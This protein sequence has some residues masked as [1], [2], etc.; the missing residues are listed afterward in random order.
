M[1]RLLSSLLL[2]FYSSQLYGQIKPTE[3][4]LEKHYQMSHAQSYSIIKNIPLKN[5]GPSIMGGRVV[6]LAVNPDNPFEFYVAYAT[7]GVWHTDNNGSSFRSVFDS[8]PTQHVGA[9][10]VQWKKNIIWVGTG[11]SNS[12]R[13]SYAGIGILK[14]K[15]GGKTWVSHGL[16]DTHHISKIILHPSDENTVWVASMGHLYTQNSERGVFKTTDSGKSW[17]KTLFISDKTGVI[18]LSIAPNNPNILYAA[19]W[20]R[21]RKSWQFDRDGKES[22]IYK[23]ID[24]GNNWSLITTGENG[25]PNN[26]GIGRIGLAVYN[27]RVIYA[28]LDNQNEKP[29]QKLDKRKIL[30]KRDFQEMT[31]K[32]FLRLNDSKL[33]QYIKEKKI[34]TTAK[35]AKEKVRKGEIAPDALAY[36]LD[37]GNTLLFNTSVIGAE[38]Y[39]S[40]NGGKYWIK[41]HA[42]YL[43]KVYNSY[44]YYFGVIR[45]SSTDENQIFVGGV[46]LI[47]S[48][49]GG[50]SF[51]TLDQPNMHVDHHALWINP[52]NQKHLINGNDGGVD[53]SFDGG[54]NW[55][56][57]NDPPVGQL[58]AV[59][60]DYEMPYNIYGGFQDNGV[61]YGK[62]T[63]NRNLEWQ[64]TGEYPYRILTDGDGMQTQIDNTNR[65]TVIIGC[66]FGDYFKINKRTKGR[67]NVKPK[68]KLGQKP[69][70][71]N[72][73]TPILLSK[74][75]KNS[76]YIGSQY[77]H[78]SADNGNTFEGITK[79]LTLGGKGKK[80]S[81]IYGTLTTIS[82]SPFSFGKL[83]VGSDDGLIHRTEDNGKTWKNISTGLPENMWVSRV[84][85]SFHSNTQV[86]A[87]LNG[88][89]WDNFAP[90]VYLSED[91]GDHWKDISNDLPIGSIN[92]IKEDLKNKN[93]LYLGTDLGLFVSFN[94]GKNWIP[95]GKGLPRVAVHDLAIQ[96][97]ANHLI[98]GTHGR[99][100]YQV[101]LNS[102][103]N[104]ANLNDSPSSPQLFDIKPITYNK[105]W[106]ERDWKW[107]PIE[108][109]KAT[110]PVFV[111]KEGNYRIQILSPKKKII[112]EFNLHLEKGY[113]PIIY[114]LTKTKEKGDIAKSNG[115]VYLTK[116]IYIVIL[117]G[118]GYSAK[119]NLVVE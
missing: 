118:N 44:G 55:M 95:F 64:E 96:P 5:I 46:P 69:Y 62:H 20:E 29:K 85:A 119:K 52:K 57:T 26:K 14:S 74:H 35:E 48:D 80:G 82:E 31:V 109:P 93:I 83:Y 27:D 33:E 87:S 73:Q 38:V 90:M 36:Y 61:W 89:R 103:Q 104:I 2:I 112:K 70:R 54:K 11:E 108:V 51:E 111:F 113:H 24:G 41:T 34:P 49:N 13:S 107:T 100:I 43:D 19:S 97:I 10:A 75:K 25:F 60:V 92:V 91:N 84:I 98:V 12:S 106:G 7:G 116:G 86:Y 47:K 53:L 39:K 4:F 117:S 77:L 16:A 42:N 114:N 28:L 99:S 17:A 9:I 59:T 88:Y 3:N 37:D 18:D 40:T 72:W 15:D 76:F 63:Y 66:Q 68:H 45:V 71:F 22:G 30:K 105:N 32:E 1:H 21:N 94:Q 115:K 23:S 102:I 79:D 58:Y 81:V 65:D 56:K 50:K 6:D 78:Y 101:E 67:K 8:A 110:L